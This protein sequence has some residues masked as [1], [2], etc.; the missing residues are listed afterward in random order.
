MQHLHCFKARM[1]YEIAT[2]TRRAIAEYNEGARTVDLARRYKISVSYLM[3]LMRNG[4]VKFRPPG[5]D[6]RRKLN[7]E[8]IKDDYL[9]GKAI[10]ALSC[11]YGVSRDVIAKRL[12]E[13]NV[14]LRSQSEQSYIS[15]AKQSPEERKARASAA[16]AAVRGSKKSLKSL[17]QA[18]IRRQIACKSTDKENKWWQHLADAGIVCVKQYAVGKYNIDLAV[19]DARLAI[20]VKSGWSASGRKGAQEEAKRLGLKAL[21]WHVIDLFGTKWCDKWPDKIWPYIETR[22]A[23][24]L[25]KNNG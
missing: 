11:Q 3:Q 22:R 20:E 16:H 17:E 4:G 15:A 19:P 25:R 12:S 1:P 8:K 10:L 9:S 2:I 24:R 18:A 7:D 13:A 14:K 23:M 6:K 5:T 21:G